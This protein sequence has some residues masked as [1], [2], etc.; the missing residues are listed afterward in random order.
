MA[1]CPLL[2]SVI[3]AVVSPRVNKNLILATPVAFFA[4]LIP[5]QALTLLKSTS[6]SF[7]EMLLRYWFFNL[8][9]K[10]GWHC[11]ASRTCLLWLN[12]LNITNFQRPPEGRDWTENPIDNN[13]WGKM[14]NPVLGGRTS[15]F[16]WPAESC[17]NSKHTQILKHF[18]IGRFVQ[19]L[20]LFVPPIDF[21][22]SPLHC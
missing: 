11:Q 5:G 17:P 7:S 19:W 6:V 3:F 18:K 16:R 22:F 14:T 13:Q 8:S 12:W 15:P 2:L 10:E 21:A 1:S 9:I 4:F 20:L